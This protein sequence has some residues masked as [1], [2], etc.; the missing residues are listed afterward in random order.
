MK[1]TKQSAKKLLLLGLVFLVLLFALT[2][3]LLRVHD[4]SGEHC[5]LCCLQALGKSACAALVLL[6]SAFGLVAVVL[7]V[8]RSAYFVRGMAVRFSTPVYNRVKLSD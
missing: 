5:V 4:C 6:F 1:M 8:R 7:T 2:A 3:S